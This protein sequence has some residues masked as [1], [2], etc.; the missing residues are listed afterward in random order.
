MTVCLSILFQTYP[1]SKME[2][3]EAVERYYEAFGR[4]DADLFAYILRVYLENKGEYFPSPDEIQIVIGEI[5]R[6]SKQI[7]EDP[8]NPFY[9]Q[10][11]EEAYRRRQKKI[12][13]AEMIL[14]RLNN[15]Q[16]RRLT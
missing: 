8:R 16:Q 5:K 10:V 12:R 4:Y 11:S 3:G 2:S 13:M 14:N 15:I 1:Y 7:L 6:Q 9:A